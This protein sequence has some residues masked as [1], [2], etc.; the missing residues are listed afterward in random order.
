MHSPQTLRTAG[1]DGCT[2]HLTRMAPHMCRIRHGTGQC[3]W[4]APNILCTRRAAWRLDVG[5]AAQAMLGVGRSSNIAVQSDA[6]WSCLAAKFMSLTSDRE[7]GGCRLGRRGLL[8]LTQPHL[9]ILQVGVRG[10]RPG[11][12]RG[13]DAGAG[14]GNRKGHRPGA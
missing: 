2:P 1:V 6:Y 4:G 8:L 5:R 3:L 13:A 12:A 10:G 7:A 11:P 14:G 9:R